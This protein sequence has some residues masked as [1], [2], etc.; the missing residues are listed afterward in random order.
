MNIQIREAQEN[1][2]LTI[3]E[4]IKT[5]LGYSQLNKAETLKRLA[6]FYADEN[7][8][9]EAQGRFLRFTSY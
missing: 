5:D 9:T 7:W 6:F 4:L 8:C 2:F 3:C 1:D